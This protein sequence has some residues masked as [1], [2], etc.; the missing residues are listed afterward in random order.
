MTVTQTETQLKFLDDIVS[1]STLSEILHTDGTTVDIVVEYVL[2]VFSSPFVDYEHSLA[3]RLL[4]LLLFSE[5]AFL[6]LYVVAIGQPSQCIGVG[7][8]LMFHDE[9][10]AIATLATNEAVTRTAC[11]RNI[12]RG[13]V[14]VV[15][16]TQSAVVYPHLLQRHEFRDDINNVGS[17]LY[18]F[19][20]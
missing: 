10:H 8:L 13:C 15:E 4:L 16:G 1:H 7:E 19:Y 3:V 2:E 6:N 12:E 18:A 5:F 11:G 14:V 17:I 9:P 20:G